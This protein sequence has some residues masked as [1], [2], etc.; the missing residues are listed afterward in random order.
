MP[1]LVRDGVDGRLVEPGRPDQLSAAILETLDDPQAR[2]RMGEAAR[3]RIAE[4]F[5]VGS[6]VH[7]TQD[8]YVELLA[9][10]RAR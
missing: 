9:R 6:M 4:T 1:E 2:L 10:G 7:H 3:R 5:S 8:L